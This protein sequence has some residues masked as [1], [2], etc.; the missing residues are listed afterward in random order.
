MVLSSDSR[1]YREINFNYR[2][3]TYHK[4]SLFRLELCDQT[5]LLLDSVAHIL[6]QVFIAAQCSLRSDHLR[7]LVLQLCDN[8]FLLAEFSV[9]LLNL[10]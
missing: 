8:P 7:Q 1:Y 10:T 3:K 2:I 6:N 9:Q 4:L 5:V